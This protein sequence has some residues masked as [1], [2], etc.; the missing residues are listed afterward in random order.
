[1]IYT[2]CWPT[3]IAAPKFRNVKSMANK[4][5]EYAARCHYYF[6]D[7]KPC[8]E[9]PK[10]DG[11]GTTRPTII[12]A[13]KLPLLPSVTTVQRIIAKPEL[14]IW[15]HRQY[16]ETAHA[17]ALI[18]GETLEQYEDRIVDLTQ[19]RMDLAPDLGTAVHQAIE[20][21]ITGKDL[22][23]ATELQPYVRAYEKLAREL[24]LTNIICSQTVVN[25]DYGYAGIYD[26]RGEIEAMPTYI[27]IKTSGTDLDKVK[28]YPEWGEQ[29]VAYAVADDDGSERSFR[30]INIV[31][32]TKEP[33]T[34][35]VVGWINHAELWD[36]FKH[37]LSLWRSRNNCPWK[38][39]YHE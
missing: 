31:L 10:A 32:S 16:I 9:V 23:T 19:T 20:N 15:K 26:Q 33:G 27:D 25:D 11:N 7:G 30:L 24:Q 22:V 6:P 8:W 35:K 17:N 38:G 37:C 21:F 14:D 29:L 1:M 3:I 2:P 28:G 13:R 36:N 39:A 12:H 5:Y 4:I 34:G 18:D